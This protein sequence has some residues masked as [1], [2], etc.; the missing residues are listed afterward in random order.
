M[1]DGLQVIGVGL[2]RTGSM[3]VKAALERLG[4]GPCYHGMEAL[5][6]STDGDHW[7]AAYE[8][9]GEFDW[10]VI[11][12]GYRATLDWPTIYFWEQLSAAY[13][14][15]KILLT[16]RDPEL[17]WDSH[18]RMFQVSAE[19]D[20]E[21]TDEERQGAKESGYAQVEEALVTVVMA[22]FEGQ[23]F[24]KAHCLRVFEEH[25]ERVRCSLP[26]ERLLVYRVQEGWEPLCWFLGVD[27]PDEPFP[28]V[29]VGDDL[30]HNIRTAMRLAR[31]QTGEAV[32]R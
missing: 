8:A 5:R 23:V 27:V 4:F 10:S 6:R 22:T 32:W 20:Q 29:N 16:E 2:H 13:P 7:L 18:V 19:L 28:R 9:G 15:A 11:F 31:A 30:R 25:Y 26:A 12:E 3:S 14:D 24:D 21:R 17:W 1:S